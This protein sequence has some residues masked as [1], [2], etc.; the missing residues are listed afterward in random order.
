MCWNRNAYGCS[1]RIVLYVANQ[2]S[3]PNCV[4]CNELVLAAELRCLQRSNFCCWIVVSAV[5]QSADESV[6]QQISPLT[7]L[8]FSELVCW[9]ISITSE[10]FFAN[11]F[12]SEI[13]ISGLVQWLK[14]FHCVI[15]TCGTLEYE[16]VYAWS[17][18]G[19]ELGDYWIWI[20]WFVAIDV[21]DGATGIRPSS[22][23]GHPTSGTGRWFPPSSLIMLIYE[24][25]YHECHNITL[26]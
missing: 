14:W 8:Y 12:L 19:D 20:Y 26:V 10:P 18:H 23:Q 6:F 3:L 16:L 13:Y 7:I 24:M 15:T 5:N 1:C 11:K 17:M 9:W 2:F 4:V 25:F 22:G 21:L